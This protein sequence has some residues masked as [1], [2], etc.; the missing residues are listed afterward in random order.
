VTH[1]EVWDFSTGL[2]LAICISNIRKSNGNSIEFSLSDAKQR[3]SWLNSGYR[4]LATNNN[5]LAILPSHN[6]KVDSLGR[7][8]QRPSQ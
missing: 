4:T 1:K 5:N 6:I 7:I 2:G 8:E 3:N